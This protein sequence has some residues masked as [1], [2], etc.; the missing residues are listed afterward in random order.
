[1][2]AQ[3]HPEVVYDPGAAIGI[4]FEAGR[5]SVFRATTNDKEQPGGQS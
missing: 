3:T 5:V 1:L 2:R 4:A